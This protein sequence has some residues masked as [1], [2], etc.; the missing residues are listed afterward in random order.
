MENKDIRTCLIIGISIIILAAVFLAGTGVGYFIPRLVGENTALLD[1]Q[2]CPP[3]PELVTTESECPECPYLD[4]SGDAP[5]EYQELFAPFWETWQIVHEE[6]VDQPVDDLNL[7]R[8]AIE[9][10]L[11]SLGDK[12]TSYMTPDEFKQANES[13]EGEYEGIGAWVDITGNYVEIISPMRNSPADKA[14][15][16]PKDKVIAIRVGPRELTDIIFN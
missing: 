14:G 15:L 9:G 6:Y 3:C 13:L 10:M 1:N 2:D 16:Q 11:S 8:G 7:M 5:E 12:H 4:P